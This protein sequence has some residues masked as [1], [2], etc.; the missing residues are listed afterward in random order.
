MRGTLLIYRVSSPVQGLIPTYAGNTYTDSVRYK[1]SW[2]HPHVCGEH[3][4]EFAHVVRELGSSPRMRGT[5]EVQMHDA[6]TS[7]LI[8][9]Y[10]GNTPRRATGS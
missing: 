8:P 10:A 7:G 4:V 9:T 2:A 3:P 6:Q 1:Y 5:R